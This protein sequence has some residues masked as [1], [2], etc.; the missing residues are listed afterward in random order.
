[1]TALFKDSRTYYLVSLSNMVLIGHVLQHD[2]YHLL[3]SLMTG[4]VS[5]K[6]KVGRMKML[7]LRNIRERTRHKG[8]RATVQASFGQRKI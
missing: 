6:W 3:H 4:K 2:R 1:M 7:W 8:R 5:E